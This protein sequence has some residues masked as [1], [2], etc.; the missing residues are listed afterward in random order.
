M[1]EAMRRI[2]VENARRKARLKLGGEFERV[3]LLDQL[4]ISDEP[5]DR[6]IAMDEALTKLALEDA[7]AS[8]VVKLHFFVGMPLEDVAKL[9]DVSRATAYRQWSYARSWLKCEIEGKL[10]PALFM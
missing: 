2:L 6:L 8:E 7:T 10:Q 3:E 1:A 5:P 4:A 9:L